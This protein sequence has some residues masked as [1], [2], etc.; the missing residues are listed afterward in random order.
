MGFFFWPAPVDPG[1]KPVQSIQAAERAVNL[2]PATAGCDRVV[3]CDRGHDQNIVSI[4]NQIKFNDVNWRPVASSEAD[5][6]QKE[7]AQEKYK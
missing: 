1:L 3:F 4:G 7:E 2:K 6:R 5:R